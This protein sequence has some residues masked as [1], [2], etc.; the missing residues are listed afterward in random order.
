MAGWGLGWLAGWAGWLAGW[1]WGVYE[2]HG[3]WFMVRQPAGD[4]QQARERMDKLDRCG[5]QQATASR[6]EKGALAVCGSNHK[7]N[8][9]DRITHPGTVESYWFD[10]PANLRPSLP[11]TYHR[12][13]LD[14]IYPLKARVVEAGK[15]GN[16]HFQLWPPPAPK[17]KAATNLGKGGGE[18]GGEDRFCKGGQDRH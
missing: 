13:P 7:V 3:S 4:S 10:S 5:S 2:T 16:A 1:R 14:T 17:A 11:S 12:F 15:S 9:S 18:Q 6:R 8:P